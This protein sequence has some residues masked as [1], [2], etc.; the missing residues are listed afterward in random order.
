MNQNDTGLERNTAPNCASDDTY[1]PKLVCFIVLY[2]FLN[3]C[4][5]YIIIMCMNH[6]TLLFRTSSHGDD[7]LM[8]TN[9]HI[10]QQ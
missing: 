2:L 4:V 8:T 9:L 1:W 10:V 5:S 7:D 3:R 6:H